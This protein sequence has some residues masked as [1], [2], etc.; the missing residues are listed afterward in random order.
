MLVGV[1]NA[2]DSYIEAI[3]I[4]YLTTGHMF[5]SADNFHHSVEREMKKMDKVYDFEDFA[6]SVSNASEK[7]TMKHNDF[8]C[9][10]MESGKVK[11]LRLLYPN[12]T[13]CL[14]WNFDV[15]R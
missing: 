14:L 6:D 15:A 12:S 10:K 7:V 13:M 5:M 8:L 1:V 4:K 3:T 2:A 11:Y 9:L